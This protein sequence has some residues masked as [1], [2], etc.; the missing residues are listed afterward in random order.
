M[1]TG[2]TLKVVD[3]AFTGSVNANGHFVNVRNEESSKDFVSD[4][5]GTTYPQFFAYQN[6]NFTWLKKD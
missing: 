2:Y 1:Y 6:A 4:A 5:D 3:E